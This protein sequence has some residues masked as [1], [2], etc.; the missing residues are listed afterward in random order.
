[1]D[2]T[3]LSMIDNVG[4]AGIGFAFLYLFINKYFKQVETIVTEIQNLCEEVKDLVT[5]FNELKTVQ[6]TQQEIDRNLPVEIRE[7]YSK[8]SRQIDHQNEKIAA[9]H[10]MCNELVVNSRKQS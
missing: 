7:A 6:A 3:F 1:M 8:I 5:A 9:I 4:M 2:Q 10:D